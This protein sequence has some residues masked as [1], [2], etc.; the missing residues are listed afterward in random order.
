MSATPQRMPAEAAQERR[1]S[2]FERSL[3]KEP[4][5]LGGRIED[6]IR[7][8][9]GRRHRRAE[10]PC[11]RVVAR[12]GRHWSCRA[13]E[14]RWRA[15]RPPV[16]T[17][18]RSG[19]AVAAAAPGRARSRPG[20][21]FGRG[22][23]TD[24]RSRADMTVEAHAPRRPLRGRSS[25]PTTALHRRAGS[26]AAPRPPVREVKLPFGLA[27]E[28]AD[29]AG[30]PFQRARSAS[31]RVVAARALAQPD[32]GVE[33]A[34]SFIGATIFRSWCPP[35]RAAPRDRGGQLEMTRRSEKRPGLGS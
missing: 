22:R 2:L 23:R 17:P 12:R 4:F 20:Q 11:R 28:H 25:R 10:R 14:K 15:R 34:S 16:A 21:R 3:M 32:G 29:R 1:D 8:P 30:A 19:A 33:H 13:A 24:R 5:F 6:R 27:V 35:R 18:G 7:M 31:D 9:L 26:T